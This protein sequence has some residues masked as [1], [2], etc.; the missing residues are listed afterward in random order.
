MAYSFRLLVARRSRQDGVALA[1]VR[2]WKAGGTPEPKLRATQSS[3]HS[4]FSSLL[5]KTYL[6]LA[7]VIIANKHHRASHESIIHSNN[8]IGRDLNFIYSMIIINVKFP[9]KCKIV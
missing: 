8:T 3:A 7:V 1:S 9:S 6:I 4:Y 5:V 2:A